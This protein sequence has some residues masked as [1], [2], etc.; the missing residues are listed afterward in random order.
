MLFIPSNKPNDFKSQRTT[1]IITTTFKIVF[2]FES[3]GI[4]ALIS[5]SNTPTTHKTIIIVNRL[6]M[7]GFNYL[8]HLVLPVIFYK[9]QNI[10]YTLYSPAQ[11]DSLNSHILT[12]HHQQCLSNRLALLCR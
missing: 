7:I 6:I 10:Y 1:T 2:I 4:Y 11:I 5:Q 9:I 12:L 3:I 8:T